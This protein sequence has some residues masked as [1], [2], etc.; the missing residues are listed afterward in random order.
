[1]YA[2]YLSEGGVEREE[3]EALHRLLVKCQQQA[4]KIEQQRIRNCAAKR[5]KKN[6]KGKNKKGKKGK[7]K[8]GKGK[9][10]GGG[11]GKKESKEGNS[12]TEERGI[13]EGGGGGGGG[14]SSNKFR[15]LSL[16]DRDVRRRAFIFEVLRGEE[17]VIVQHLDVVTEKL[18]E[19]AKSGGRNRMREMVR[20][21]ATGEEEENCDD[22][23]NDDEND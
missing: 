17:E 7:K 13:R 20:R 15:H 5:A 1:M 12:Q 19:A 23:E 18:V 21:D 4:D 22:N 16:E 14:R 10:G 2:P 8:N 3:R 9:R 6:K 11:V